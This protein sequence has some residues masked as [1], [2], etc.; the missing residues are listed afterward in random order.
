[1]GGWNTRSMWG[2]KQECKEPLVYAMS[3]TY[4]HNEGCI[5]LVINICMAD[6]LCQNYHFKLYCEFERCEPLE[7]GHCGGRMEAFLPNDAGQHLESFLDSCIL[8]NL[9]CHKAPLL[10]VSSSLS[11]LSPN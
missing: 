7:V 6:N 10:L 3:L 1:M 4:K 2:G 11:L 9:P 8:H 5:Y